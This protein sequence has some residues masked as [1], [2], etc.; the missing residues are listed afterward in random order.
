MSFTLH[1]P[2]TRRPVLADLLPRVRWHAAA[3]VAG[4]AG[5]IALASQ[6][7]VPLGFT[8]VPINLATF[9]VAL[10]GGALGVRRGV[11]SVLVFLLAGLVGMPVYTNA[12]S[13]WS[14]FTGATGGYLVGYVA[15]AAITGWAARRGRDRHLVSSVAA[16]V[17]G[18]VVLYMLGT[19]W[20]AHTLDVPV[21]G[22]ES[23]G[24]T[25]GVRPFLA[26]DAVKMAAAGALFPVAWSRLGRD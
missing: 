2:A 18:N 23:S 25:M 14:T 6:L 17:A 24:F 7:R 3:L 13:G 12:G 11:A 15:L 20:L 19:L 4:G 5:L 16:V 9:A 1:A 10:T 8:P 21:L 26:G 22:W